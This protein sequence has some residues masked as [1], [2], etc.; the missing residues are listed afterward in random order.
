MKFQARTALLHNTLLLVALC[1]SPVASTAE[2]SR[3]DWS[4]IEPSNVVLFSPGQASYEW[5][6]STVHRAAHHDVKR[7]ESCA[8][9]H[10]EE[11]A[12]KEIGI[13]NS[14][15]GRLE[16]HPI[17]GKIGFIDLGVQAA[18][19]AQNMY[20]RFQWKTNSPKP[21]PEH[22]YVRFDG[23]TWKTW[24]FSRLDKEVREGQMPALMEDRISIMLDD[25]KVADFAKQGCW[26]TCHDGMRDMPPQFPSRGGAINTGV[27]PIH[28]DAIRKYLPDSRDEPS[29]WKT[30]KTPKEIAKLKADG[31]FLELMQWRARSSPD[32]VAVDDGYVLDWGYV[33]TKTKKGNSDSN[34]GKNQLPQ[35]MWDQKSTGFRSIRDDNAVQNNNLSLIPGQNAIPFD[36]RVRWQDGD[37]LPD[38][39]VSPKATKNVTGTRAQ[40]AWSDGVWT[41]VIT[42][43][44]RSANPGS[45]GSKALA[46]GGV[47]NVGFAVH[48]DNVGTRGH[49]VSFVKTLGLG[50][51]ADIQAVKVP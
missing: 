1:A 34:I 41:V 39:V 29:D 40:G 14:K 12:E 18:F 10:D 4:S 33:D 31:K 35:F 24:G 9:C 43:P 16:P 26:L 32:V 20:L 13:V 8:F 11:D 21:G 37:M 49:H 46:E 15:G 27:P 30:Q 22:R 28:Q 5:V 45:P 50:V 25:G 6:R 42:R 44:L 23:K 36:P 47:Y 3:I 2:L 7:G 19:D 17:K 38:R 48:D 51:K